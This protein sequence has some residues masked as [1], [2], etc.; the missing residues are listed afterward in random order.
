[1]K[2]RILGDSIRLRLTRPEVDAVCAGQTV[3]ELTHFASAPAP[4]LRY[5]IA[6]VTGLEEARASFADN[7]VRV[8][9]PAAFVEHW[10]SNEVVGTEVHQTIEDE[11]SLRILVEKDFKCLAPREDEDQAEAFANPLEHH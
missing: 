8:E 9:L 6:A 2:L 7:C 3:H 4:T 5:E 1:M 11:R 10:G